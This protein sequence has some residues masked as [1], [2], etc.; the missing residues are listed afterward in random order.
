MHNFFKASPLQHIEFC[1][2]LN[3]RFPEDSSITN[4]YS[5]MSIFNLSVFLKFALSLLKIIKLNQ[6]YK[7]I[8]NQVGE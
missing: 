7:I 8:H 5:K 1:I 2:I 3:L 4:F 6:S